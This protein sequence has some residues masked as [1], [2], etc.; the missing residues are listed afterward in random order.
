MTTMD[1][2]RQAQTSPAKNGS[3]P[4][5]PETAPETNT[6]QPHHDCFRGY[7]G[8]INRGINPLSEKPGKVEDADPATFIPLPKNAI[9]QIIGPNGNPHD[10]FNGN[11]L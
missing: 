2:Q 4:M 6:N 3:A 10:C 11:M 5:R 1:R 9:G 7:M 8:G